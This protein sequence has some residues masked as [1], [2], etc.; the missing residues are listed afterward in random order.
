MKIRRSLYQKLRWINTV[1]N[2]FSRI[3]RNGRSAVT[4]FLASLGICS[5]V[6]TII[7]VVSVMNGFQM[8]F[9]DAIME[10]TSY[11]IRVSAIPVDEQVAFHSWCVSESDIISVTPFYEAQSLIAGAHGMES[12]AVIR[13]VPADICTTDKGFGR[14]IGICSGNFDL[15]KPGTIVLGSSLANS[16]DVGV[17]SMVNLLA[18]S[19]SSEVQL[20]SRNRLFV[21]TGVFRC[22][23][24]DINAGYAFINMADGAAYFGSNSEK[25][26]GIKLRRASSNMSVVAAVAEKF[27]GAQIESWQQYN[28]S[29]FGVLRV[30]KNMLMLLVFLIFVVAGIN[31]YNGMR[32]LVFE[33][34]TEIS[35]LSAL[36]APG[37]EIK[38][39]FI[40]RGF[41]MG[42]TGAGA[43]LVLGLLLSI[44]VGSLF[45]FASSVM[46][47]VQYFFVMLFSPEK[48]SYIQENPMYQLYA[49]IP[50]RI[51]PGEVCMITLFG[52][53][54]PLA[55][56]YAASR[57]V[58]T[59][60]VAEVLHDE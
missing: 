22:G 25:T 28:R 50:A 54:A 49:S 24:A 32:R 15:S 41:L 52:I 58:L 29:F 3:D 45:R 19:G 40:M 56:S 47:Y 20:L 33:R 42:I 46:Y 34:R 17:G 18:L 23:Y 26:Y 59:M 8:G 16:L 60:T 51:M 53:I 21:V 9:K 38:S 2:R 48:G 12:A 35:I 30:E 43:G 11:H 57:T 10:I 27:P 1:V 13:A 36:G 37:G 55:A 39:I 14:E 31:I 5:G 7:V 44:N 6:M 4:S